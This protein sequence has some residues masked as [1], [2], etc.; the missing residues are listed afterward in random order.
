MRGDEDHLS[1]NDQAG[2]SRG[3]IPANV[4][5]LKLRPGIQLELKAPNQPGRPGEN[6]TP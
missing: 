3:D 1:T 5:R 2:A 4:A 6:G